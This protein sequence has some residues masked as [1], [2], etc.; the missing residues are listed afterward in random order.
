MTREEAQ[1]ECDRLAAESP[2][3]ETHRFFPREDESG[4]WQVAKVGI[5]PA[6]R[7]T[8]TSTEAHP[9]PRQHP[10]NPNEGR[11]N[12]NWGVF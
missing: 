4:D 7:A 3:R 12:P 8:G 2:E 9:R 5:P 6:N 11:P 10:E 1:R